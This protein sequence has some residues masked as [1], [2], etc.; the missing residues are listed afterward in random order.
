MPDG[1]SQEPSDTNGRTNGDEAAPRAVDA[2]DPDQAKGE[3]FCGVIKSYNE[4]RGFGFVVCEDTARRFGRDV[5]LS[6]EEALALSKEPPIGL[7]ASEH[8][9]SAEGTGPP[10]KEGDYL[11]F[12]VQRSTE[13][14]PQAVAARRIRRLR[15][16]VQK[17]TIGKS[18]ADGVIIVRGDG[19]ADNADIHRHPDAALQRLLGAEVRVRQADCGQLRLVADD[20]VAFCCATA[21]DGSQGTKL[22]ASLVEL[23]HTRRSGGSLLGCFSLELPRTSEVAR[24]ED[25]ERPP[26][27]PPVTIDGHAL[28]DRVVLAGLPGD[29]QVPELM[30]LFGKLGATEAVVTHPDIGG[31]MGGFASVSFGGPCDVGRFLARVAH[32]ISEQLARKPGAAPATADQQKRKGDTYLAHLGACRRPKRTVNDASAVVAAAAQCNWAPLPALPTPTLQVAEGSS[33]LVNWS[34]VSL[35]AGYLIELRPVGEDAA[36]SSVA[37]NVGQLEG[38]EEEELPNGLLGPNCTACRVNSL[39]PGVAYE[40]RVAYFAT[41]GCHSQPSE[42]SAPR[43]VPAVGSPSQAGAGTLATTPGP[44]PSALAA[45]PAAPVA[46]ASR[47]G[48]VLPAASPSPMEAIQPVPAVAAAAALPCGFGDRGGPT[49]STPGSAPLPGVVPAPYPGLPPQPCIHTQTITDFSVPPPAPDWI[50]AS[51]NLIPSPAAPELLPVFENGRSICIQWPMVIHATA[52]TV[53]LFEEGSASSERFT[54][55]VPEGMTEALVELRVGNLQPTA[56]AACVRCVAPCGSES[57]PSPWSYLPPSWMVPPPVAPHQ[58]PTH[59]APPAHLGGYAPGAHALPPMHHVDY[60]VGLLPPQSPAC[61][62]A[63]TTMSAANPLPSM[64]PPAA[65]PSLGQAFAAPAAAPALA[66]GSA[67]L[68]SPAPAA[69]VPSAVAAATAEELAGSSGDALVLD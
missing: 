48:S 7:A 17:G 12:Q 55:A 30:R 6:K 57:L 33:L 41:C 51:G 10:V 25:E 43:M 67:L 2:S 49:G 11:M 29:L 66:P 56:Y 13:G 27:P 36:W 54:R 5:Y 63:A 53:E 32:T 62:G 18:N 46:D 69:V 28:C 4:R 37:A 24:D 23:L 61:L 65:P 39:R 16:V 14:F 1:G 20:E 58:W 45:A 47:T 26:L 52:Y 31:S 15:G 19:A 59:A 60:N 38:N 8:V 42:S 40:A 34:Q 68:S 44:E 21:T 64:P 3:T 22:E 50:S 35:A 9:S